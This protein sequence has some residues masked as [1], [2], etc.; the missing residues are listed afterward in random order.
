MMGRVLLIPVASP[1]HD[2]GLVK[3]LLD[4]YYKRL[5]KA[6]DLTLPLI[7]DCSEINSHDITGDALAIVAPLTGGTEHLIQ[8]IHEKAKYVLLLPHASMNSLPSALE[9]FS[10]IRDSMKAWIITDWPISKKV[11]KFIKAWRIANEL[12]KMKIGLIGEP[13][14]WLVH[15]SGVKVKELLG[16][17]F[18]GLTFLDISL[19]DLYGEYDKLI[20][21]PDNRLSSLSRKILDMAK[22]VRVSEDAVY[23]S[24]VT[25]LALK[26][27]IE[28]FNLDAVTV[29]CFDI[30]KD[31][32][33]TSCLAVSLINS[34]NVIIG[35]E[36]DLPALITM[37]IASKLADAP[38]VM[39]NLAWIRRNT[40]MIAHCTIPLSIVRRFDLDSHYES[41]RGVGII[42]YLPKGRRVTLARLDPIYNVIRYAVGR[43]LSSGPIQSNLCR[44]QV[45]MKMYT[46]LGKCD[47][48]IDE[49]IGNHYVIT[50][51][52]I[53]EEL[54]Y[55][56]KIIGVR[57]EEV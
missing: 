18:E 32:N 34:K 20:R 3:K 17:L 33:T 16:N 52:D 50:L 14:P 46:K 19:T 47:Q 4:M 31:L 1:L 41:G 36:G 35:C 42:G 30:I 23:K 45:K 49:A 24:L 6:V 15:S 29:R 43:I 37:I 10:K 27:V 22:N 28:K 8:L 53:T 25:Y 56:S 26:H 2:P 54:K 12:K 39:G 57:L 51:K 5:E 40:L 11:N 13:S 38:S 44:T 55:L 7:T 9:A 21:E 48:F